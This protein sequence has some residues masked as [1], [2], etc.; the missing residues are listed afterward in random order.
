MF[1]LKNGDENETKDGTQDNSLKIYHLI[2]YETIFYFKN[3]Q[4]FLP[5]FLMNIFSSHILS[6]THG[7][8]S[9][10]FISLIFLKTI[11]Y[12]SGSSDV[13]QC[14]FCSRTISTARLI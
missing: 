3:T 7:L 12:E 11:C 1:I 8:H 4:Q 9:P 13:M 6:H 14:N 5:L 2:N 10:S